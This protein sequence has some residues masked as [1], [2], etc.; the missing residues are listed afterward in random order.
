MTGGVG[1]G[2]AVDPSDRE[3]TNRR[4]DVGGGVRVDPTAEGMGGGVRAGGGGGVVGTEATQTGTLCGV[5]DDPEQRR[6]NFR[7]ILS[8][9]GSWPLMGSLAAWG[10]QLLPRS[11]KSFLQ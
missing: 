9:E 1:G 3:A 5:G 10:S 6:D 2:E 4:A 8:C 7:I 11:Y